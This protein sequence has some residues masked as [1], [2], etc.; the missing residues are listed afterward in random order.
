MVCCDHTIE[1]L[2]RGVKRRNDII[3]IFPNRLRS[4]D[5]SALS[6]PTTKTSGRSLATTQGDLRAYAPWL[7]AMLQ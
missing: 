3:G 7:A 4:S 2:S 5:S 1:H 6:W